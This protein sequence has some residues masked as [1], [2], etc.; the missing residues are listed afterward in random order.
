[1]ITVRAE[2]IVLLAGIA[3]LSVV[4]VIVILVD[5]VLPILTNRKA[6]R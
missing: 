6:H 2:W 5:V 4:T 1:M 3:G